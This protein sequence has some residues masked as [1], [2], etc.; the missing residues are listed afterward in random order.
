MAP[1]LPP[2][3]LLPAIQT[4]LPPDGARKVLVFSNNH[5]GFAKG[6]RATICCFWSFSTQPMVSPRR[7]IGIY[8]A[9]RTKATMTPTKRIRSGSTML[10]I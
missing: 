4:L 8:M 7:N 3:L 6:G 5:E 10:F 9:T 2:P 1:H